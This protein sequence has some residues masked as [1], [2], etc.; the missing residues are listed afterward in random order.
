MFGLT[1]RLFFVFVGL[2]CS[3]NSSRSIE[4]NADNLESLLCDQNNYSVQATSK[5]LDLSTN[6]ADK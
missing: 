2:S 4:L 5:I 6:S 1:K 3:A